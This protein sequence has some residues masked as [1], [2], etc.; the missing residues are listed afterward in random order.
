M[1]D[2]SLK[3]TFF[4]LSIKPKKSWVVLTRKWGK[5]FAL[6]RSFDSSWWCS[7]SILWFTQNPFN[8]R[9]SR[10]HKSK[11]NYVFFN[12]KLT[13]KYLFLGDYVD[14]GVY[15]TEVMILLLCMKIN[16]P[17][18]FVLLRG[19]HECRQMTI[20]FTFRQEILLKYDQEVFEAF[21][22]MFDYMPLSCI[23]NGKF[24]AVHAG[25]SPELKTLSDLNKINRFHGNFLLNF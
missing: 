6:E 24:I 15:S 12:R 2:F 10:N 17:S 20:S 9:K 23:I 22:T 1:K 19:N 16:Y 5:S 11:H 18:T 8:R 14:R 25:I 13:L 3:K 7:W 21:C 4:E